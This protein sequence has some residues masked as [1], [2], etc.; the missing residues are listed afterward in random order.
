ME[1][2]TFIHGIFT[3][4]GLLMGVGIVWILQTIINLKEQL[5]EVSNEL[6]T[7]ERDLQFNIQE[8]FLEIENT[9][10]SIYRDIDSRFDKSNFKISK[11]IE[12]LEREINKVVDVNT[13]FK[14][15]LLTD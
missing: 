11:E 6:E 13:E 15:Q 8:N 5:K 12:E 2:L 4:I 7:V 14:K 10:D 1:T 3:V 9:I